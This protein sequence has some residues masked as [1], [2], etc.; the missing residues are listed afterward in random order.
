MTQGTLFYYILI[1]L[2]LSF[3]RSRIVYNTEAVASQNPVLVNAMQL[4]NMA[5]I[6]SNSQGNPFSIGRGGL[7]KIISLR[8]KRQKITMCSSSNWDGSSSRKYER[9]TP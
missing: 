9:A 6:L 8:K 2:L 5:P 7:V 1:W 3:S 4:M